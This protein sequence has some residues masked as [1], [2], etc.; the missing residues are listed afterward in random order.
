MLSN[1]EDSIFPALSRPPNFRDYHQDTK[2]YFVSKGTEDAFAWNT[3][4]AINLNFF[5]CSWLGFEWW[6][7]DNRQGN[8]NWC[9]FI[10]MQSPCPRERMFEDCRRQTRIPSQPASTCSMKIPMASLGCPPTRSLQAIWFLHMKEKPFLPAI[11]CP[12]DDRVYL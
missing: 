9:L 3:H 6:L 8:V 1:I 12:G 11:M 2:I 10:L 7:S 5:W 4:L